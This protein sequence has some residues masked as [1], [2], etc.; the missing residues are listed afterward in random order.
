MELSIVLPAWNEAENLRHLV[1]ALRTALEGVTADYEIVVVDGGSQDGTSEVA[2]ALGCTAFR[3]VTPGYGGALRE[4]FKAAKGRFLCT[5]DADLSHPPTF[6]AEMWRRREEAD[7]VIAS[8]YV[9]G[10]KADMPRSRE[11]LSLILNRTFGELL[12]IPVKDLS[13]GFRLYRREALER[14]ETRGTNF[15]VLQELLT[16]ILVR[17]GRVAEV[18]FHYMPR[19]HGV[20]HARIIRF[21]ISYLG[22]LRHLFF[23]RTALFRGAPALR[24][25]PYLLAIVLAVFAAYASSLGNGWVRWD[26]DYL[27]FENP[28]LRALDAP[29]VAEVFD[30]RA[31]EPFRCRHCIQDHTP[32]LHFGSQYTPLADLSY[33]LDGAVFG[34]R[35]ARPFHVQG[36]LWHA[37][38]ACL[39]FLVVN[40]HR[41]AA[42]LGLT[43]A[44]LFALHPVATE[45]VAWISG[46]R[47]AMCLAFL[48]ASALAWERWRRC[49][50][51]P[52]YAASLL[53]LAAACLS[54][55]YAVA[56]PL[57][58]A[59]ME[60]TRAPEGGPSEVPA[61]GPGP[62]TGPDSGPTQLLPAPSLAALAQLLP[63][64]LFAAAYAALALDVGAREGI[65]GPYPG[66]PAAQAQAALLAVGHYVGMVFWPLSL[67]PS[68][69]LLLTPERFHALM[70][71]GGAALLA[72]LGLTAFALR[73]GMRDLAFGGAGALLLL[74]PSLAAV[75][76]QIVGERYVYAPLAFLAVIAGAAFARL[77]QVGPP[78]SDL[79][80]E[81]RVVARRRRLTAALCALLLAMGVGTHIRSRAW[82]SDLALWEDAAAKEPENRVARRLLGFALSRR[83]GPGDLARAEGELLTALDLEQRQPPMRGASPLPVIAAE[84]ARLME[85]RGERAGAE[86]LLTA[87]AA[88]LPNSEIAALAL[89]R[90]H[91]G[92]GD[93]ERAREALRSY[94]ARHPEAA[95]ARAQLSALE[96][97]R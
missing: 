48:L 31:P 94:L 91:E 79:Q 4:G 38:A 87:V 78:P 7:L 15:N 12:S 2:T 89:A 77:A 37:L 35:D 32:R 62:A 71:L 21:G 75:G 58:L 83:A 27:V 1:P 57:L 63:H 69:A 41:R 64:A 73:K 6:I 14:F 90:L 97:P 29:L 56:A 52:A 16:G 34:W 59:A 61:R 40:R 93:R 19:I 28:A 66:G 47:T 49:R 3:Q 42:G 39:L 10:G 82:A 23:L 9:P 81:L 84:A 54:K 25:A 8:R 13:S 72:G 95:A 36:V 67:R 51:A 60:W 18:P 96:A 50:C 88:K 26:D 20:S 68:Y 30:P 86:G 45:S 22:S 70:A 76:T 65:V 74:A 85:A 33:A 46:R 55:Q 11:I 24:L 44:L 17:G 43:A 53:A 5:L 92:R 80:E